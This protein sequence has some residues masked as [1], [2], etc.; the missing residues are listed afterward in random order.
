MKEIKYE[1]I[2]MLLHWWELLLAGETWSKNSGCSLGMG[3]TTTHMQGNL[4]IWKKNPIPRNWLM[5]A[6]HTNR[7]VS[8]GENKE[9]MKLYTLT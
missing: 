9:T 6:C 4:P 5:S 2:V 3:L 8:N 7:Q 1:K